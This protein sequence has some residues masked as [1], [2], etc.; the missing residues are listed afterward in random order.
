LLDGELLPMKKME[1][2]E[3]GIIKKRFQSEDEIA[4]M[5]RG[6]FNGE[7]K[8]LSEFFNPRKIFVIIRLLIAI[9]FEDLMLIFT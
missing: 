4:L 5:Q 7:S 8:T 1:H 9:K 2:E 3:E 6:G